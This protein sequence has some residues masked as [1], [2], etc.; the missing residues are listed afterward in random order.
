MN[1]RIAATA[2]SFL[3]LPYLLCAQNIQT[4]SW[5]ELGQRTSRCKVEVSLKSGEIIQG[6]VVRWDDRSLT[7]KDREILPTEISLVRVQPRRRWIGRYIG[8]GGG[9]VLGTVSGMQAGNKTTGRDTDSVV[10]NAMAG[11]V[12]GVLIGWGADAII[13]PKP[14]FYRIEAAR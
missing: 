5:T 10:L 9:I 4:I 13:T 6:K 7:V 1:T 14:V 8:L 12:V 11:A 2:M 3:G